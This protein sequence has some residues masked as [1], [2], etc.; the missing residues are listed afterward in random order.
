[1]DQD[2]EPMCWSSL[3]G[4]GSCVVSHA[5]IQPFCEQLWW[6]LNPIGLDFTDGANQHA[7][8]DILSAGASAFDTS[9]GVLRN[10][11]LGTDPGANPHAYTNDTFDITS[12]VG[13]GGTFQLRFAEVDN[14]NFLNLG[15]DNVSINFTP[16]GVPEPSGIALAALG[17]TGLALLG[18]R[19]AFPVK[20]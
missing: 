20:R 9:A 13:S 19:R 1:M 5:F 2:R 17:L 15:V 10:F 8:V 12:Q 11:Y 3:Y 16:A 18:S 6:K 7:R 4:P 14:Q